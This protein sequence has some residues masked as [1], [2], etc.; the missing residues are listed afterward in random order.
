VKHEEVLCHVGSIYNIVYSKEHPTKFGA[1]PP[2]DQRYSCPVRLPSK[3]KGP[4]ADCPEL[5][6][7]H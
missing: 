6:S 1:I 7:T 2:A 3:M 5:H 4:S